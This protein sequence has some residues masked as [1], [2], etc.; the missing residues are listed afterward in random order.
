METQGE[1]DRKDG[2]R[3][4]EGETE[5]RG[6]ETETDRHLERQRKTGR[7][8]KTETETKVQMQRRTGMGQGGGVQDSDGADSRGSEV[9]WKE[10]LQMLLRWLFG[11]RLLVSL[12]GS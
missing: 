11:P 7:T 9:D 2:D 12:W 8:L 6:Q 10:G 4:V 3:S 5:T 1:R